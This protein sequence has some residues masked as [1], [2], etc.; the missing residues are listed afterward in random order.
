MSLGGISTAFSGEAYFAS[1]SLP[2]GY[3][4]AR[5]YVT[6]TA[7]DPYGGIDFSWGEQADALI[8]QRYSAGLFY[9]HQKSP[10]HYP[11]QSA[12]SFRKSSSS[13]F[14]DS[15]FTTI[16]LPGSWFLS[17]PLDPS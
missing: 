12:E 1:F 14:S 5:G 13:L 11:V 17:E 4:N 6:L 8:T 3:Q 9:I 15:A 7:K 16:H 10:W 2:N